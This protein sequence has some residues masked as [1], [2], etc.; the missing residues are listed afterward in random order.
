MLT[1]PAQTSWGGKHVHLVEAESPSWGIWS[2]QPLSTWHN[3]KTLDFWKLI[4]W[5]IHTRGQSLQCTKFGVNWRNLI[6]FL[7]PLMPIL[8]IW[9]KFKVYLI[10]FIFTASSPYWERVI[11]SKVQRASPSRFGENG[12]VQLTVVWF[13]CSGRWLSTGN[14]RQSTHTLTNF[15][16]HCPL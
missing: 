9:P 3:Y 1:C 13:L 16:N 12:P 14:T 2:G 5:G 11:W 15:N 7:S 8:K 4:F 6:F 10:C